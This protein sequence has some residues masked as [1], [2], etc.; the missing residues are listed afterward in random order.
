MAEFF[1]SLSK[2]ALAVILIGGGILLIVASDPPVTVCSHQ[3][4][5]FQEA[6]IGNLVK[7]P[8]DKFSEQTRFE[9]LLGVCKQSNSMGGCYEL[10]NSIRQ[11][12][13]RFRTVSLECHSEW[14][15]SPVVRQF[16]NESLETM[17]A[18][19][20]GPEG[21]SSEGARL[22]WYQ[23]PQMEL[24]CRLVDVYSLTYG[25]A[26]WAQKRETILAGLPGFDKLGRAKA[27]GHSLLAVNCASYRSGNY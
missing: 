12:L 22:S 15:T 16:F 2:N 4:E 9:K 26:A 10:F 25:E 3:I 17:M 18:I 21:P 11:T 19:P 5:K 27:W 24:F 13:N 6:E 20:W 8:N 1:K 14:G 7:D 23:G